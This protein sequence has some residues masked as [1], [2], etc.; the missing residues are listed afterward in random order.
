MN[1]PVKPIVS[2]FFAGAMLIPP[3]VAS[4]QGVPSVRAAW[5]LTQSQSDD[6][7]PTTRAILVLR[8]AI[9][10]TLDLGTVDGH[11][12]T[13]SDQVPFRIPSGAVAC[14]LTGTDWGSVFSLSIRGRSLVLSRAVGESRRTESVVVFTVPR[15]TRLS[16]GR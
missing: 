5:T 11:C 13:D 12:T 15:N 2:L 8:G 14:Q 3:A 1:H 6:D 10:Y 7:P 9:E 16:V 4:A